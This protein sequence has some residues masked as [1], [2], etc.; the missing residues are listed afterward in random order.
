MTRL[1][2]GGRAA[3]ESAAV[4]ERG[5]FPSQRVVSGELAKIAEVAARAGLRAP[6]IT[7]IGPVAAL[8]KRLDW[9]APGPLAGVSVAVTRAR[10]Q[11]SGLA[12][13]LR[14][15]GAEV[16]E[17]PA[18]RIVPLDGP[19]PEI[20]RYDLVCVTSPNGVDSLFER[21]ASAGLDARA[22]AGARVA[23]IG[24]GTA[25]ALREHG[26][27][28]DVVPKRFLAEGL[29]EALASTPVAR[30]LVARA[31]GAR[32]V[33]PDAL[34]ARGAEVDVLE[35]YETV[36]ESPSAAQLAAVASSDYVTFTSSSTV[37]FFFRALEPRLAQGTRIVSIGPVT[38]D[39][40]REHGLDVD[41]EASRHDI[42]GLVMALV[43][44]AVARAGPASPPQAA[45]G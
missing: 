38:S 39:T 12:S 40:L 17:A 9:F 5:T 31:A 1:L 2:A 14:E 35:L 34:R 15:L 7:V 4:I 8:H 11:A 13:R 19:A 43:N 29:V 42:D 28:A 32:E 25:A 23:A 6:A 24:P 20:E 10:A 3:D 26:V 37:R 21:L 36:A 22:L 27:I 16:V 18:I 41:V 33:L 44:D 30:A 45:S